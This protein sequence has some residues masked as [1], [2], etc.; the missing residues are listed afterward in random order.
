MRKVYLIH[1]WGGNPENAWFPWLKTELESKEFH[2][3]A[4]E[5]PDT[6]KPKIELWLNKLRGVVPN[7]DEQTYFVGH[8]IGCQAILRY[9]ESLRSETKVGG[10]VLVAPWMH[11]DEQTIAEEGPESVEI[12]RP[13][14]E[15]PIDFE[16][17][18]SHSSKF[19]ALFSNNDPFVPVSDRDIFKEMLGAEVE[20]EN[21][22]GHFDDDA[23]ITELP[24]ALNSLLG[25]TK[26]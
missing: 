26:Q 7:P 9:L 14:L 8:S 4:P 13:W 24:S 10:V 2:V 17:V 18:K 6:E 1:G 11:L 20:I 22:K 25:M 23:E 16:K 12:A 5:M 15:T 19:F 3:E 21:E